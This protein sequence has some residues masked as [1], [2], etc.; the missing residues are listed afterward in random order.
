MKKILKYIICV[1]TLALVFCIFGCEIIDESLPDKQKE[2]YLLAKEAGYV[3]TYEQW[4]SSIKGDKGDPGVGIESIKLTSSEGLVDTYTI[5]YSNGNTSSFNITN[6][7]NGVQGIQGIPG[8]DGYTPVITIQNGNWYIDGVDTLQSAAGLKGDS[9]VGIESIKLTSSEGLVDTYTITFTDGTTSTFTITNGQDGKD[10]EQGLPGEDGKKAEFR[11]FNGYIQWKYIDESE[12]K[13]L[14]SLD[15]VINNKEMESNPLYG[16][17][18]LCVGDSITVGQGL[19]TNERWAN[20]LANKYNWDLTVKAQGGISTSSYYYIQNNMTD[21]SMCKQIEAIASMEEKP[22]LIILWSGHNDI[23]YRHCPLGS[24]DDIAEVDKSG[25][26][27]T[28]AD[29]SSYKGALRYIS[30]VVHTYA[31]TSTLVY[32]TP[33]WIRSSP[34]NLTVP[35]GTT[36]NEWMMSEAI[37]EG[38][39][40]FGWVPINMNLCGIT[41][42]TKNL[43]TSDG[44]HPNVQGS[45]L[46][47]DYLSHELKKLHYYKE[48]II[49][50]SSVSF[51][52]KDVE[53]GIGYQKT[54]TV[55]ITPSNASNTNLLWSSSNEEVATIND[56]V[57]KGIG[58]GN[59]VITVTSEDG[60]FSDTCNVTITN[61]KET[62]LLENDSNILHS[63]WSIISY[64]GHQYFVYDCSD[65]IE[66]FKKKTIISVFGGSK[67]AKAN[68]TLKFNLYL[69][70]LNNPLPINWELKESI[71]VVTNQKG[72]FEIDINDLYVPDGYTIGFSTTSGNICTFNRIVANYNGFVAH[73][74]NNV[75]STTSTQINLFALDF[76]VKG[77]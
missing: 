11:Y 58:E 65:S 26:I 71:S 15:E 64:L 13:N 70:D 32:L 17:T 49:P 38:A 19:Q 43:Y 18:V 6:G 50:V 56:G 3:G 27:P 62:Y 30:E 34:A 74:Y 1:S 45:I 41:P 48:P 12:W 7:E 53:L 16:L 24:F 22:D 10:G 55:N 4:L 63:D 69:V 54:L 35:E 60:S 77:E 75:N 23:S 61:R 52:T 39:R 59:C 51:V 67:D 68:T 28:Y 47:A 66:A 42:Y 21:V 46:I 9:G 8:K 5:F 29:K 76:K 2:I 36:D 37:Y 25:I 20:L 44:V 33:E 73:Y 57:L 14:V 72:L 31:P 40:L